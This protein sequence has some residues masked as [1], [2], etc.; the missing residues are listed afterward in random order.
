MSCPVCGEEV[1]TVEHVFI[2]CP[3]TIQAWANSAWPLNMVVFKDMSIDQWINIIIN[4]SELLKIQGKE[5]KEFTLFAAILCDQ[6][7]KNKNQTVWGN[8]PAKSIK[9]PVRI[10][11]VFTQ[12]KQAWQSILEEKEN[13]PSWKPPPLRWIK[14]NFDTAVK[15]D[16]VVLTV[17]CRDSNGSIV[18]TQSQEKCLGKSLWVDSKVALLVVSSAH[19]EG[20]AKAVLEGD[21]QS[22]IK[23]IMN[24]FTTPH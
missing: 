14:C 12:H 15:P 20:F 23:A 18:A 6:I 13:S 21:A 16:K 11:K 24:P 9:L 19:K 8:Q 3:I 2:C 5:A 4:Q 1:E 10:N 17:V 7:W 22:V